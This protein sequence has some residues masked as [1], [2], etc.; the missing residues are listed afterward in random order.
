MQNEHLELIKK[1]NNDIGV[2][3]IAMK[4][5]FN[6]IDICIKKIEDSIKNIEHCIVI[7]NQKN[8]KQ[9]LFLKTL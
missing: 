2:I 4:E 5:K 8:K 9:S 1:I 3:Y 6:E 7:L